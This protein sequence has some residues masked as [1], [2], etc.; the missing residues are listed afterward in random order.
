M[1]DSQVVELFNKYYHALKRDNPNNMEAAI[2]AAA[3]LT[4]THILKEQLISLSN[5]ITAP[6]ANY[7]ADYSYKFDDISIKL[8]NINSTFEDAKR[9]VVSA[10][11][12]LARAIRTS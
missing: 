2:Q 5:D 11:D 9:D 7:A 1:V 12:D 6:S 4:Q 3:V 10:C 8:N